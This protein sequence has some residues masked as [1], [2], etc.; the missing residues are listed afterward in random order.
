MS[1]GAQRRNPPPLGVGR[2]SIEYTIGSSFVAVG[3]A[4]PSWFIPGIASWTTASVIMLV[5]LI[6]GR[7]D[8]PV[9][10]S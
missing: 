6:Y 3:E 10:L 7:R 1:D 4:P 5:A 2:M 8:T 9:Y